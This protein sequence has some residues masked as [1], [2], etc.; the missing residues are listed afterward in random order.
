MPLAYS[1][2]GSII[3]LYTQSVGSMSGQAGGTTRGSKGSFVE[4]IL[5]EA[6]VRL[7]WH[8]LGGEENRLNI[9]KRPEPIAIEENYVKNL[10]HEY[11]QHHIEL[12]KDLYIYDV[13]FDRA[14]EID[15][16][17]VLGI[18][19][20]AY[21]DQTMFKRSLKEF[22]LIAKLRYPELLFCIFQLENGLGGDYGEASNPMQ[23]G[24]TSTHT[25]LS[26]TSI[27]SLEIITL[28]DGRR[29]SRKPIH[30]PRFFKELPEKNVAVCV[31]KF[32]VLLEPFV[33]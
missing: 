17:F 3:D 19:C 7:A 6:I 33:K 2:Y 13:E 14:V 22:E 5:V 1:D 4:G 28:L 9:E 26:H 8:E 32:R 15:N 29:D 21:M 23:L 25:L 31:S 10:K 12:N 27:A 16:N 24:S 30:E 18:E 11:L 20:K